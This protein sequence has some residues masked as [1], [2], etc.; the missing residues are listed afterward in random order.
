MGNDQCENDERNEKGPA[1]I[2][3]RFWFEQGAVEL[4]CGTFFRST[5][6]SVH[7]DV[8]FFEP[9][10][11]LSGFHC[12]LLY[13]H[14]DGRYVALMGQYCSPEQSIDDNGSG[15]VLW[16]SSYPIRGRFVSQCD[17]V[18]FFINK[19]LPIP[20]SLESAFLE[21]QEKRLAQ[22]KKATLEDQSPPRAV[23]PLKYWHGL[24]LL[25]RT[26]EAPAHE[27]DFKQK[28]RRCYLAVVELVHSLRRNDE[29]TR[30]RGLG[31]ER[32]EW[33][34]AIIDCLFICVRV[35]PDHWTVN[36]DTVPPE[37][38]HVLDL[39]WPRTLRRV[40]A[41]LTTL[42]KLFELPFS[43]AYA[44][45]W[46]REFDKCPFPQDTDAAWDALVQDLARIEK[47]AAQLATALREIAL[48]GPVPEPPDNS[49]RT[50]PPRAEIAWNSYELATQELMKTS[51]DPPT[52]DEAY[53][54]LQENG[55]SE[56]KLPT[57]GSWK[58]N[59]RLARSAYGRQKNTIR[60]GRSG[61]SIVSPDEI[62]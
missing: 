32:P 54:W 13:E 56:Y 25:P 15:Y 52:D 44:V 20:D 36:G 1:E 60:Y 22:I 46:C 34:N 27:V 8:H 31:V 12:Y 23:R 53:Q 37:Y 28:A 24:G 29:D 42:R 43:C 33:F 19:H 9:S 59:V 14:K 11:Q 50:L 16:V 62:E 61:R 51:D 3:H 6:D 4:E 45:A 40:H 49:G 55:P 17:V 58:R 2:D 47:S 21:L 41:A 30:W 10:T 48:L 57:L 5:R 7:R 39:N 26:F 35:D 18:Q 38:V